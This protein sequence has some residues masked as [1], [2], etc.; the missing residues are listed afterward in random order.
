MELCNNTRLIITFVTFL[1]SL[2]YGYLFG[3]EKQ[4][5]QKR[6]VGEKELEFAYYFKKTAPCCKCGTCSKKGS[7]LVS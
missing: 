6:G 3:E 5:E 2:S 7:I 1:F 4:R